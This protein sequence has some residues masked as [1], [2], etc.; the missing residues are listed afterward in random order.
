[1]KKEGILSWYEISGR[2]VIDDDTKRFLVDVLSQPWAPKSG[3]AVELGCG[4]AP[5]LRRICK[6]GFSGLGVDISKTAIAMA[7]D[8][9]KGL[10]IRFKKADICHFRTEKAREFDLAIDGHCL[11]CIIRPKDRKAF[12][13]NTFQ[14][15]K[16]GGL[17]VVMTM[18]A[19]VERKV[20]SK[21]FPAQKLIDGIIYAPY[22]KANENEY[23]GCRI[24]DGQG[25][26]PTRYL[27]HWRNILTEIR[28]VGFQPQL[29]RYNRPA[30]QDPTGD[31]AVAALRPC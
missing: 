20:F 29:V 17:F 4:T 8:Q 12:L 30:S 19:P 5:I 1:M 28:K 16:K 13:K 22:D 21:L 6:R 25:F 2:K 24:F 9:S 15:V 10:N 14:L 3:K 31:L 26:I 11:H 18:C 23:E 27:G 7:R